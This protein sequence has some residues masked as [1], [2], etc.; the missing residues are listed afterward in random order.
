[1]ISDPLPFLYGPLVYFY[2]KS[3]FNKTEL[4][5]RDLLHLLPFLIYFM[6]CSQFYFNTEAAKHAMMNNKIAFNDFFALY[7]KSTYVVIVMAIS[8]CVYCF[9]CLKEFY[10]ESLTLKQ[11]RSWFLLAL[12]IFAFYIL[13]FIVFHI[14]IRYHLLSGCADYGIAT[15]ISIFIYLFAWFGFVRPQVF[16]GY[17]LSK[18]LRTVTPEKYSSST[19]T[20]SLESELQQRLKELM[21]SEKLYRNENLNLETLAQQLG[22]S[23]NNVSQVINRSGM[24]FFEY[25]N[26]WRI[27]E[28]KKI[29]SETSKKE[30]NIIEV[31]YEVGFNNKVSFNKFF[32]KS[33]GLTPTEFRKTSESK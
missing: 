30:L 23:R 7:I 1:M 18:A 14:L 31:A 26:H 19:L 17:P 29:L 2:F 13:N 21:M 28:A 33:T 12:G 6:Y 32:K 24:N 15:S 16:D 11:V 8:L 9:L 10:R 25:V 27:E 5:R 22:V 4:N 3:S 20:I